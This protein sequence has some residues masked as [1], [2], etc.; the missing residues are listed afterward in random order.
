MA[1]FDATQQIDKL[2]VK[3]LTTDLEALV[4]LT[5]KGAANGVA[6][7][8]SAGKIPASQIPAMAMERTVVVANESAK[9][10]LTSAQVQNGDLV[11]VNSSPVAVY[12]VADET[13][14]PGASAFILLLTGSTAP[15]DSVFGR[16][17]AVTAQAGDYDSEQ[18]TYAGAVA[19]AANVEAAL[20]SL[21]T[22]VDNVQ[23][24]PT[25]LDGTPSGTPNGTLKDFGLR[26]GGVAR[27]VVPGSLAVFT[28]NL[29]FDPSGYTLTSGN[30]VITFT[31]A[32]PS[33][34]RIRT[35]GQAVPV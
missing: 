21:Q 17:G 8:D 33:G 31:T 13:L 25:F 30:T 6:T 9:N 15:V 19:G 11:K 3:D 32:P 1:F 14:L 24:I 10:A 28:N 18:I 34:T 23:P 4:P 22:Q 12:T 35:L 26:V 2:Q 29:W 20:D 27:A 7:L 5:Q 16:I